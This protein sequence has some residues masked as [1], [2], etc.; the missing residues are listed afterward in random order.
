[1][2]ILECVIGL[3]IFSQVGTENRFLNELVLPKKCRYVIGLQV[4]SSERISMHLLNSWQ[5]V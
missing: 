2:I 1:M 5:T 3:R 4:T